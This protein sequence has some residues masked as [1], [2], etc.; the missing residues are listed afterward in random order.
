MF[1]N[2]KKIIIIVGII[3]I[4]IISAALTAFGIT[5]LRPHTERVTGKSIMPKEIIETFEISA[6]DYGYSSIIFEKNTAERKFL[7]VKL[8]DASQMYAVQ[9]EGIIKMG[10]NG[11]DVKIDEQYDGESKVLKITIPKAYIISH[12][13]PLNDSAEVIYDIS[14]HMEHAQIGQYIELFNDKKKEIEQEI[15]SQGMLERARQSA[16]KQL[17]SLLNSIPDI[18]DNYKLEFILE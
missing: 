13:A 8:E 12:D 14:D 15:E 1:T 16:K 2:Q 11:K 7:F 10:I 9:F 6:L 3:F 5:R 18:H 17:E 4:V